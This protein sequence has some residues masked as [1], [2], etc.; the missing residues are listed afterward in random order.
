M[1]YTRL[2][3]GV[4]LL[5][6]LICSQV[7]AS[8]FENTGLGTTARGMGGAFRAIANDWTAAY[9][10]PAGYAFLMD[11][12][13]GADVAFFENR[14]QL[15]P[16]YAAEDAFGNTYGWGIVNGQE[17]YNFHRVL[18]NPAGGLTVRLP[19]WGET[20]FGFSVYQPFDYN[21]AWRL[22][23]VE[24]SAMQAYNP[25]ADSLMP[26]DHYKNDLDIVAFQLTAGREFIEDKLALGIGLQ[27]LRADLWFSDLTFRANP[28][29]HPVSDRPRDRVPEFTK[30][31]GTGWG[32]GLRGGML[33]KFN[34]KL[35]VA[36]T[37]YLPFDITVDGSTDYTFIMPKYPDQSIDEVNMS[38]EDLL[39]VKGEDV[40]LSSDFKSKIKLPASFGL[41]LA[42]QV[43]EKLTVSLDAEY[44][45]WSHFDGLEFAYTNF[46]GLRRTPDTVSGG[47]RNLEE[48]FFTT[49]L[50]NP[51]EW[52]DAGKVALGLMYD[53]SET[54]TLL[55]GGSLDQ[56]PA[57]DGKL[58]PQFVDTGDKYGFNGGA[59]F[60][61]NRWDVGIVQTYINYPDLGVGGLDDLD[62]DGNFDNFPGEY[63]ANYF[64]TTLSVVYRF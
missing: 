8:G 51:V 43:T 62:N 5:S 1:R 2:V 41:G 7:L 37:A 13:L 3:A 28:R 63:E 35:N 31:D 18:N 27:V 45:M 38:A 20:V 12:Q 22:Y 39:F 30:N 21:I 9:Y 6:V 61:V 33:W 40:V 53:Y 23:D 19:F 57:R 46:T 56:S 34:D 42:Y 47:Y 44:T 15:K 52:D 36:V 24:G 25:K 32:F 4:L 14:H 55:A 10:N 11:N 49:S 59:I 29:S 64:E 50:S 48:D 16:A 17:V 54:I 60:H 26:S 58:Y